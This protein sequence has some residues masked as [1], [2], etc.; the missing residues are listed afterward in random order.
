VFQIE[1]GTI[2][3]KV[4]DT[5]AVGY[6]S[7]WLAPA[8]KAVGAVV[9]ADYDPSSP[10]WSCQATAGALTASQDTTTTDVPA[11][12]CGPARSIPQPA[13]TSFN[14]DLTFLQDPNVKLGLSRYLFEN[15]T[16]EAYVFFGLNGW[17]PPKMIG[18][19]RLVAGT[20]GG[21]AR[22]VL[23]ADISLPLS[24]RPQIDF[25]TAADHQAVPP[26][27]ATGATAGIPGTWTPSGATAPANAAGATAAAIV[28]S[29]AT[30]W[31]TGQYV[32]GT[33]AGVPGQ[34]HW[35]GTAWTAGAKP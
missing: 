7:T 16:K 26:G 3:F 17:D 31:T 11:T 24:S 1:S 13:S 9:V 10:V 32:Q 14:L 28:A 6:L 27:A 12:F 20:I 18:R 25:G 22:T 5:A 23:S 34:M 33:T 2:A 19:V 4:V 15:D 29:P 21:E 8:G 30:A 35:N